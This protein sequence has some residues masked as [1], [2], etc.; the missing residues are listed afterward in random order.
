MIRYH[1]LNGQ[2]TDVQHT[3]LHV[4]D[5]AILRGYGI[6]DFFL[7]REG[8]PLFIQ[9][10]LDRFFRSA[11]LMA[12]DLPATREGVYQTILKV[13]EAN[14]LQLGAIRLLATGGYAEDSFT[15]VSPNWLVLAHEFH[16]YS[17][18]AYSSGVKLLLHQHQ[19]ELP[20]AK[21]INYAGA[22]RM[23]EEMKAAGA[24]E[25]L[26]HNGVN[27]LESFR[28]N[29]FFVFD[30]PVLATPSDHILEGI[31]RKHILAMTGNHMAVEE[32]PVSVGEIRHAREA[33][34]TGSNKGLLPVTRIGEEVIGDGKV[35]P[36]TRKLTAWWEDYVTYYLEKGSTAGFS[37]RVSF[38]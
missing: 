27:V 37:P 4:T 17:P 33:F 12:L 35:G 1:A 24:F 18:E 22:I 21:S 10:Y 20:R 16:N 34:L 36:M 14:D 26:Y 29:I 9:D 32:R 30:G 2:L 31:T 3:S 38:H 13:I 25:A 28:S 15:P 11:A 7:V 19:R 5:L 6:F 8:K 23:R